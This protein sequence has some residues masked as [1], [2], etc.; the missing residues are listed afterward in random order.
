MKQRVSLIGAVKFIACLCVPD[1]AQWKDAIYAKI[2]FKCG[3]R[4]YW[5][6]WARDVAAIAK[7]HVTRIKALL[8]DKNAKHAKAFAEFL[9]G[10]QNN[11]NHP[12]RTLRGAISV[13]LLGLYSLMPMTAH[14][15]NTV[16][17]STSAVG[18]TNAMT[19]WGVDTAWPSADNMSPEHREHGRQSNRCGPL[20]FLRR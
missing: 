10:L 2:V 12:S 15:Q 8:D 17:F 7:R 19:N 1:L 18:Q 4:E 3:D 11:L 9:A 6:K 13:T 5:A 20:E 16:Y 14:A